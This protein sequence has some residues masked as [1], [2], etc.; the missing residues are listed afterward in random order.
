MVQMEWVWFKGTPHP[1]LLQ[2]FKSSPWRLADVPACI[3]VQLQVEDC[4]PR[5]S[6]LSCS[7][8]TPLLHSSCLSGSLY[9]QWSCA[10]LLSHTDCTCLG[11]YAASLV[12]TTSPQP[13]SPV[14]SCSK[15]S[16]DNWKCED[17]SLINSPSSCNVSRWFSFLN[18]VSRGLKKN[19]Q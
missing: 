12:Y 16:L 7:L 18:E 14:L 5:A 9:T 8:K 6:D 2:H 17:Y 3:T 15:S 1:Q 13:S 11:M 4:S 19:W 10:L